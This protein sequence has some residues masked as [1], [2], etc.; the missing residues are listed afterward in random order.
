MT[1]ATTQAD[2]LVIPD[3]LR[4]QYPELIGLI[5]KSES[6]NDAER[7]YWV[8]ILPIMTPEQVQSLRDILDNERRQLKAIDEKYAKTAAEMAE[9]SDNAQMERERQEKAAARKSN[10]ES[11]RTQEEQATTDLL[12]QIENNQL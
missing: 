5:E 1:D 2:P 7:Q 3:E 8:N 4:A 10:E 9:K 12:S 11:A 6:M